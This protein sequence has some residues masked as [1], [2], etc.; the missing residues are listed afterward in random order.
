MYSSLAQSLMCF[1]VWNLWES[2]KWQCIR[3]Q[4]GW[5]VLYMTK[6]KRFLW[7]FL[8][9]LIYCGLYQRDKKGSLL[10]LEPSIIV[11]SSLEGYLLFY[12]IDHVLQPY[13]RAV[14]AVITTAF[15]HQCHWFISLLFIPHRIVQEGSSGGIK[16]F[17]EMTFYTMYRHCLK[18]GGCTMWIRKE[19]NK[20]VCL[21]EHP[22]P[23]LLLA[24]CFT[25][26][27]WAQGESSLWWNWLSYLSFP[28]SNQISEYSSTYQ[29]LQVNLMNTQQ[30]FISQQNCYQQEAD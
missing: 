13:A 27:F 22:V 23:M 9:K 4:F 8:L 14:E 18:S 30:F 3:W 19:V 20:L 29:R 12:S 28:L 25:D 2:A 15:F 5:Q 7:N 26:Y 11:L 21:T 24:Y 6:Q 1:K 16:Y 10:F 17:P